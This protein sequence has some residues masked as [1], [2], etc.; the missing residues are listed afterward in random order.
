MSS[1]MAHP[2]FPLGQVVM[3]TN[4]RNRSEG[5]HGR[6]GTAEQIAQVLHRHQAGDWGGDGPPRRG[7]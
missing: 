1:F 4:L 7:G 2:R 5:E 6:A 3:T